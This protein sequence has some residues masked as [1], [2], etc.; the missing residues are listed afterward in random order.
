QLPYIPMHIAQA[1]FIGRVRAHPRR[2]LQVRTL[3]CLAERRVAMEVRLLG[4]EI[5][6]RPVEVEV[7][8]TFFQGSSPVPT[9]IFPFRLRWQ[10]VQITT[11]T[12]FFIQLLEERLRVV[13]RYALHREQL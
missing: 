13:P 8:R 3:R 10:A 12:L 6:G 4:R 5:V 9:S 11:P 2:P 7:I 1:Q